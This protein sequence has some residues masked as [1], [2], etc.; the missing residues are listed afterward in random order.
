MRLLPSLLIPFSWY[1][2]VVF[3]FRNAGPEFYI[4]P[5]LKV[6]LWSSKQ[7]RSLSIADTWLPVKQNLDEID[8]FFSYW[9]FEE[10][11]TEDHWVLTW[12]VGWW[13]CSLDSPI[14]GKAGLFTQEF[15][16]VVAGR[17]EFTTK[18]ATKP[19]DLVAALQEDSCSGPAT[20][21][22]LNVTDYTN[23]PSIGLSNGAPCA[24]VANATVTE[25]P[26]GVKIEKAA[27]K[28]IDAYLRTHNCVGPDGVPGCQKSGAASRSAVG[29]AASTILFAVAFGWLTYVALFLAQ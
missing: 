22:F 21:A 12:S 2:P 23:T 15:S 7:N 17:V 14:D 18:N 19:L 16:S 8:P 6:D 5:K 13:S 20:R 9:G 10:L 27:A 26:C 25:A 29:G 24:I 11:Y 4:D 28:S 3:A 1:T